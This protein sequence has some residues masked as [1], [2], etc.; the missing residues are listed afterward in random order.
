MN[1]INLKNLALMFILTASA[2]AGVML[3]QYTQPD[4]K[5]LS[6]DKYTWRGLKGEWVVVN[7]F[8]EWC[9]PCLREVPELNEFHEL[10]SDQ[11]IRL[12]AVSFDNEPD[13]ILAKIKDKYAMHFPL[14]STDSLRNLKVPRPESL[15]ATYLIGPDGEVKKRL[16]GEQTANQ[17]MQV[18][19]ALSARTER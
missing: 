10:T 8:A 16:L 11:Q 2:G 15:P 6:G 5:T 13:D 12:F 19:D 7:Y 17:L 18:I 1:R 3:Y 14:I 9:A 4:F